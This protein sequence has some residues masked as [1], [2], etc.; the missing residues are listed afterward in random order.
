MKTQSYTVLYYT[1]ALGLQVVIEAY[2][3]SR[4]K[5]V[6]LTVRHL[7]CF[8]LTVAGIAALPRIALG[9]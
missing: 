4:A 2:V 6:P 7:N 1:T 8:P 3:H 9:V 5:F